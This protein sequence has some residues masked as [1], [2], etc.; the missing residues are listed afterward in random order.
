MINKVKQP[1]EACHIRETFEPD[2]WRITPPLSTDGNRHF[3]EEHDL[4]F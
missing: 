2:A 3:F 4:S 1:K